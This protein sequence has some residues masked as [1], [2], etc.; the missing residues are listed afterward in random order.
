MRNRR[1]MQHSLKT[2]TGQLREGLGQLTT[3]QS[4]NVKMCLSLA[5]FLITRCVRYGFENEMWQ[6]YY[7]P[8]SLNRV[9]Y[10]GR[11]STDISTRY[12]FVP[13]SGAD[14]KLMYFGSR[15]Q[16]YDKSYGPWIVRNLVIRYQSDPSMSQADSAPPKNQKVP[17][18]ERN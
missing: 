15:D 14:V 3:S 11:S 13:R 1:M 8:L 16:P 2:A 10:P 5:V 9:D 17:P 6:S 4:S 12:I 18:V 7:L